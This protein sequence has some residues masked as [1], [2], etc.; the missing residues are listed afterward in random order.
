MAAKKSFKNDN[1]AMR[2][3]SPAG[4]NRET[5]ELKERQPPQ[6]SPAEPKQ[7]STPVAVE[8]GV[9][10]KRNP[11]YIETRSRRLNLLVQPALHT[12]I[13][14]LA[15]NRHTSVNDLIHLILEEYADREE[16]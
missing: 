10:M 12:R 15:E 7:E 4:E 16:A 8:T 11:L 14:T 2:F 1:P 6:T 3:I 13:K 9:P 5:K